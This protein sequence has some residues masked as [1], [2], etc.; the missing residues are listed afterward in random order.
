MGAALRS[1]PQAVIG[2]KL[3]S[4]IKLNGHGHATSAGSAGTSAR[5]LPRLPRCRLVELEAHH[6][7]PQH[8]LP[9]PSLAVRQWAVSPTFM[10]PHSHHFLL[11]P[12]LSTE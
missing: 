5:N 11:P 6:C 8:L 7:L 3:N 2:G 4:L 10:H 9:P 12:T 1:T